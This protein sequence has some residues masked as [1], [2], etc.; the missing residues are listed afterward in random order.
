MADDYDPYGLRK[1]K[2]GYIA[3]LVQ[4]GEGDVAKAYAKNHAY[5]GGILSKLENN[6]TGWGDSPLPFDPVHP[7]A[8]VMSNSPG[9]GAFKER[10]K[11]PLT[12]AYE[13]AS[14]AMGAYGMGQGIG[15]VAKNLGEGEYANAAW[16]AAPLAIGALVPGPDGGL[17]KK[18]PSA[19]EIDARGFYSPSLEASKG[20]GQEVGT[21]QQFRSMLLKAGGKPKELEAVGFDRAFPDP[22]A[23]VSRGDIEQYLRDNRV[24][25][26]ERRLG[27][28]TPE[29]MK[30]LD[31]DAREEFGRPW[32]RLT[33]DERAEISGE[34]PPWSSKFES[35][36]TPGGI[37]GSY[38]EVV[39]T[40]PPGTM[41][42]RA[43]YKAKNQAV[44]DFMEAPGVALS[45][46]PRA[47]LEGLQRMIEERDA[48]GKAMDAQNYESSHWPG[49]TNPLLHYRVKDFDA[50]AGRNPLDVIAQREYG[51]PYKQL[52]NRQSERVDDISSSGDYVPGL[53]PKVRVL[54]EMQSDWAQRARDQGTR[55]PAQVEAWAA[56]KAELQAAQK[57]V[58]QR[59]HAY[60]LDKTGNN[61]RMGP[62]AALDDLFQLG[63]AGD[64][65]ALK[66]SQEWT[67]FTE[68]LA[69]V[70]TKLNAARDGVPNAPYISN[71]SDW[72]DLGLK[73][74][75]IDAARDPSVRRVAWP[76]G[77]VHTARYPRYDGE[78]EAAFTRR[79]EGMK[80]FYGDMTPEG[81]QSGIVGTRLQKLVKGLDPEAARVEP[82]GIGEET[83]TRPELGENATYD[84]IGNKHKRPKFTYPSIPITPAMREKILKE[85]LPL[86]NV[87]ALSAL[88]ARIL[89]QGPVTPEEEN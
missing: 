56:R 10:P 87:A 31:I 72:V 17:G 16:A 84:R 88:M 24:V 15:E 53:H 30:E 29:Q 60:V 44:E 81:Y 42:T 82:H 2:A 36:S 46:R 74:A 6:A 35:Y 33:E 55:D 14:P 12:P 38:R 66:L 57:E 21:V 34:F 76:H 32:S 61:Y 11:D 26:G 48:A 45:S 49:I 41:D 1:N 69:D 40:L 22:N 78:T 73:Q 79:R 54:D 71:T 27:D 68:P 18:M 50:N 86:F 62:E 83:Y 20:L 65:G 47:E 19:R 4:E 85:G 28:I 63:T 9:G 58:E 25:L 67:A 59:V 52:S 51:K 80:S 89:G 13:G 43:A 70:N 64:A 3:E 75:L 8:E 39:T 7:R 23:K 5:D 37:P 77:E